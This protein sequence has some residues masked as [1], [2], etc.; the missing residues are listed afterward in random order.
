M[1]W[2]WRFQ[3]FA[4]F[5]TSQ[6]QL[7]F[8]F[9]WGSVY[10]QG[11]FGIFSSHTLEG[12]NYLWG[13]KNSKQIYVPRKTSFLYCFSSA[14]RHC[15]NRLWEIRITSGLK[16]IANLKGRFVAG[17]PCVLSWWGKHKLWIFTCL[18]FQCWGLQVYPQKLICSTPS[19]ALL[20]M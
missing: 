13:K 10:M 12:M 19:T 16:C 4:A 1:S 7:L 6:N 3:L 2:W 17:P 5:F 14:I 11:K 18:C 15:H 20:K 8:R 9:S